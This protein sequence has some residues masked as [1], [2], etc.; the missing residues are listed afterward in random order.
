[1]K[2]S[3]ESEGVGERIVGGPASSKPARER[4]LKIAYTRG[5]CGCAR[6]LRSSRGLVC[7]VNNYYGSAAPQFLSPTS[8]LQLSLSHLTMNSIRQIQALN[9]RELENAM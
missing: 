3:G 7:S 6:R 1:M 9:K 5:V 2:V 8:A 4:L